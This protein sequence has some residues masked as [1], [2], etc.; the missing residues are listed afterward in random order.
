MVSL[1]CVRFYILRTLSKVTPQAGRLSRQ[2]CGKLP[3]VASHLPIQ[4]EEQF[5]IVTAAYPI[6]HAVALQS[7]QGTLIAKSEREIIC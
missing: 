7:L 2:K 3:F 4:L 6:G 5:G 1:S